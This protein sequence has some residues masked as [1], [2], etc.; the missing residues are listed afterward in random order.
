MMIVIILKTKFSNKKLYSAILHILQ[1]IFDASIHARLWSCQTLC[2]GSRCIFVTFFVTF[3]VV[4]ILS[5]L[6]L[7]ESNNQGPY[8][9]STLRSK[10]LSLSKI[11]AKAFAISTLLPCRSER[12]L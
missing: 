9:F 12:W 10:T 5:I 6:L 1:L 8:D 2:I 11:W 3:M 7:N 4:L